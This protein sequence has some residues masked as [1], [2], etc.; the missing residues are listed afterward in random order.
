M[1]DILFPSEGGSSSL[2]LRIAALAGSP[3]IFYACFVRR[4]EGLF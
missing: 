4:Q 1:A 2:F 3:F